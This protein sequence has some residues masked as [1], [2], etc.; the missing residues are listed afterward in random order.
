[1]STAARSFL[2]KFYLILTILN[3]WPQ[4]K[5]T[6]FLKHNILKLEKKKKKSFV[7]FIKKKN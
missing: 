1:M 5:K 3:R 6:Q 2:R 7:L 4:P